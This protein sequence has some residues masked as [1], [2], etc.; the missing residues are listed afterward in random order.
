MDAELYTITYTRSDIMG[1][2]EF[3]FQTNDKEAIVDNIYSTLK[4][5]IVCHIIAPS[6]RLAELE[7]A[8]RFQV[9]RT[10]VRA[11]LQIL[12][13]EGF[14]ELIPKKGVVVK[15]LSIKD[16][17]DLFG[18]RVALE[19]FASEYF[20]EHFNEDVCAKLSAIVAESEQFMKK[21]DVRSYSK[22]DE[23]FHGLIIEATSNREMAEIVNRLN[24]KTYIFRFRSLAILG[25][26]KTSYEEHRGL[27][28][29][30]SA[31]D[32]ELA[33]KKAA[34]HVLGALTMLRK[35]L[36]LEKSPVQQ[37]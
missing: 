7:L 21:N 11:A 20:C 26:M 29:A 18:V 31:G 30:F 4:D 5:E 3:G 2:Q 32:V 33:G 10:P 1:D 15:R 14:V 24:Q 37:V 25:Y 8:E 28:E 22:C 34:S 36:L 9:S 35:Y 13:A 6:Q 23:Q 16:L 17:E 19:R 12:S 27:I